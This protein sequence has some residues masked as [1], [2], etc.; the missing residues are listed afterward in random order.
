L[1]K[2]IDLLSYLRLKRLEQRGVFLAL[3]YLG[4]SISLIVLMEDARRAEGSVWLT[5]GIFWDVAIYHR[6]MEAVHVGLDPYATGLERQ[7]AAHAAGKHAFTYVYPPLTLPVLRALNL[8]PVW[9]V[10]LLYWA[11]YAAS[12]AALLWA[13]TQF[14]RPQERAVMEY[15]VPLVIFFPSLMPDEVILSGNVA[16]IFYGLLFAATIAAWKRGSWRWFYLAVLGICAGS[17]LNRSLRG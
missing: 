5:P 15:F 16:Y 11:A 9:L 2:E 10:A 3:V 12:Y 14:F 8:F 1:Q 13:V 17:D 4:L 6:A 7:Y